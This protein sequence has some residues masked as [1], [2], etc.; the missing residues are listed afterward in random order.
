MNNRDYRNFNNSDHDSSV[1]NIKDI[2]KKSNDVDGDHSGKLSEITE[3]PGYESTVAKDVSQFNYKRSLYVN[4]S[5]EC[6]CKNFDSEDIS[7]TNINLLKKFT[8][9]R[10]KILASRITFMCA[11]HQRMIKKSIKR[12]RYLGLLP[13]IAS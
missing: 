13:Y 3:I 8:S 7:V 9:E 10:G 5:Y 11:K 4:R 1:R 6:P 2:N 12:A